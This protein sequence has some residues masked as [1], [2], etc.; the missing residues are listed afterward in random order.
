MPIW[1]STF[2][3][4]SVLT[5]GA[6]VGAYGT[7]LIPRLAHVPI[8]WAALAVAIIPVLPGRPQAQPNHHSVRLVLTAGTLITL[9]AAVEVAIS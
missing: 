7:P 5:V 1:G 8:E 2:R 4:S 6:A 9:G 3:S